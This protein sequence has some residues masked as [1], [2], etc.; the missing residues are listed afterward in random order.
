MSKDGMVAKGQRFVRI[1]CPLHNISMIK[2]YNPPD[3]Y[4]GSFK[5]GFK[6]E[7]EFLT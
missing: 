5:S 7:K 1:V 6:E 4:A 2:A 3:I